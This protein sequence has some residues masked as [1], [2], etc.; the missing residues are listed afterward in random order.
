VELRGFEPRTFSLRTRRATNCATAPWCDG[1]FNISVTPARNQLWGAGCRYVGGDG[2]PYPLLMS[3]E[4]SPVPPA[5]RAASEWAWRLLLLAAGLIALIYL[6]GF[7]SEIVIP[8]VV[9]VLLAALLTSVHRRLSSRIARGAAA[10]L[11]VLGTIVVI[12][13]LLTLVG[14]QISGGFGDMVQQAGTGVSQIRD[15]LRTNFKITDT[16]FNGYVD[17]LQQALTSNADVRK[18]ATKA[19]ITATHGAA[20]LFISL[21]TLFFFLYDGPRIWAWVVRLFPRS[22]RAQIDSS[23]AVAWHQLSAYVRATVIVAFVDAVGITLGAV[24]L[25]VPFPLAIGV[26][27]FLF[28]FIP[29]VGALLS[30]AVAVLLA[31]VAHGPA[32]AVIMLGVV[33]VV[34]QL[35]AHIL[36]PFI[37]GRSVKIHPLGVIFAIATGAILAGIVG[38][39]VAVPTLAVVN[40]VWRHL[41]SE[42]DPTDYGIGDE[43]GPQTGGPVEG[44]AR[45]SEGTVESARAT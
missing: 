14:T 43:P 44:T 9:A 40:A 1:N 25:R 32:T 16:Q 33:V 12:A 24:I 30:G 4:T 10:G 17:H 20:G 26:L 27:V 38:T 18:S 11:T 23:G 7:L 13:G 5:V 22:A 8:I 21:F 6:L 42:P 19:G 35:E 2:T 36:Q 29:I 34:Q 15:W 37:L 31:L 45:H 41:L 28:S 3:H 39:L